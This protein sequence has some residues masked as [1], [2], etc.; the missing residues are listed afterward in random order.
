MPRVSSAPEDAFHFKGEFLDGWGEV[1]DAKPIVFQFPP[2]K[3][4]KPGRPAGSQDPPG[5]FAELLIQRHTDAEGTKGPQPPEQVLLSIQRADKHTGELSAC[6]PGKFQ[7]G[8]PES[9]PEDQ[10]GELGAEGDTLYALQ[11]GFQLNDK[12]K[13]MRFTTS[14]V[15]KGFK[16]SILKRTYFPDLIG[17]RAYFMTVVDKKKSETDFDTSVFCVKEIR[18]FPYEKT[19]A[20][21][22]APAAARKPAPN[23]KTAAPAAKASAAKP[24]AAPPASS[25]GASQLSAEEIA[26][27]IITDTLAVTQKGNVFADIKKLK[28]NAFMAMNKHKPPV[29]A[30]MKKAVQ[31]Q[32]GNEDW[33]AATG[34]ATG[35]F[36]V[37]AEGKVEFAS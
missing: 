23:A 13:W 2:S 28:V 15:E 37:D 33:L 6:H 1:V 14:L 30:G 7:D 36:T 16:P 26:T 21:A 31:E 11:E 22:G 20:K 10:G 29:E 27:A 18:Q 4:D 17:L 5:L 19:A 3:E 8:D 34:E 25:N 24:T 12:C 9:E 32:L 35:V